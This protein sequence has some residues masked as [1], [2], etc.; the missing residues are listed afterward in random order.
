[1]SATIDWQLRPGLTHSSPMLLVIFGAGASFDCGLPLQPLRIPLAADLVAPSFGSIAMD[2]P[3]SRP[4]IDRLRYRMTAGRA[5]SL[6]TELASL[7][8]QANSSPER[9]QQLIAFRFYLLEVIRSTAERWLNNAFG[10]SHYLTFLNYLYDWHRRTGSTIR[11][12]TFN[13]DTLIDAAALDVFTGLTLNALSDYVERSDF[14]LFKLHGS[15]A[16]SR[17]LHSRPNLNSPVLR[18]VMELAAAGP[19]PDGEIISRYPPQPGEGVNDIVMPALAVPMAGKTAFE[20]PSE[21][22]ERLQTDLPKVTHV[23]VVGW[24]AAEPHAIRLLEG[25][26]AQEG[27]M[28]GYSLGVVSGSDESATEVIDNLGLAG[29]RGRLTFV[30]P[31]GFSAFIERLDMHMADLLGPNLTATPR[32]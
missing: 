24:R 28:P 17:L 13:Y 23:L 1:M 7:S 9:R 6:E 14:Q 27:L 2:I 3:A 12:A 18:S 15:T 22:L 8:E 11:I 5:G 30:E 25:S 20:C 29:E 10:F 19:L 21:H 16:W 26:P 31:A 4:I 32:G